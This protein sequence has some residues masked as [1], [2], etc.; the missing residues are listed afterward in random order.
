[1]DGVR[2]NEAYPPNGSKTRTMR[3]LKIILLSGGSGTRLWPLS[4]GVRSK[5]FLK[6]L[7]NDVGAL[8]SMCQ[9]IVR[10]LKNAGGFEADIT[11]ATSAVQCDSII[12]Q[13]GNDVEI[14][15]EPERRDTFPAI[16]LACSYLSDVKKCSADE[17]VVVMPIDA[18]AEQGYFDVI[19]E[20][21]KAVEQKAAN[22]VLMGIVPSSPSSKLGYILP[23]GEKSGGVIAVSGFVEKPDIQKARA[24]IADGALWNG[25]VFAFRMGYMENVIRRYTAFEKFEDIRAHYCDFPKNSFDYEILEKEKSIAVV[26][27]RGEWRD[28]GTWDALSDVIADASIGNVVMSGSAN[29]NVVNEL[30]VP[31]VCLGLDNAMVVASAD[32]VFVGSKNA[33]VNL[34]DYMKNLDARSMY[35]ERRWGKYKVLGFGESQNGHKYLTKLLT[36][37]DGCFISYQRHKFRDEVWTLVNGCG[38]LTLDGVSREVKQGDVI[39]I[40]AGQLH[41]IKSVR[42]MQIIEVQLG[43]ALTEDDIERFDLNQ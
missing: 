10:Q 7:K 32:G 4:N 39:H 22:I 16:A 1:M 37:N 33:S 21:A 23:A 28:L 38:I 13:L 29:T 35:E 19:A 26:P 36:F 17:V 11:V 3:K 27:Y 42:S 8:E 24:L 41:S 43:T 2:Q 20:M 25:G 9:R 30:D 6:L 31:V 12:S 40:K 5:Q 34:K 14:V 18:F 15:S